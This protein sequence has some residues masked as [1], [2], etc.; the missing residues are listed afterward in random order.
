MQV[1]AM[2]FVCVLRS[3]GGH[4][5]GTDLLFGSELKSDPIPLVSIRIAGGS[6]HQPRKDAI[7]PTCR[8]LLEHPYMPINTCSSWSPVHLSADWCRYLGNSFFLQ[9]CYLEPEAYNPAYAETV[10]QK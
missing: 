4:A 2:E 7:T 10:R 9:A 5:R 6:A 3:W 1:D 8:V